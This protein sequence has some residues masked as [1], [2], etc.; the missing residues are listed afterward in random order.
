MELDQAKIDSKK[1]E[2]ELE[3]T[4]NE[5]NLS[6][7]DYQKAKM[8]FEKSEK[9]TKEKYEKMLEEKDND[10]KNLI[11]NRHLQKSFLHLLKDQRDLGI[12]IER[13]LIATSLV[14]VLGT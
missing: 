1:F 5:L 14:K 11:K 13:K 2:K 4:K 12:L 8:D 3:Q 9:I 6:K 7:E 10:I